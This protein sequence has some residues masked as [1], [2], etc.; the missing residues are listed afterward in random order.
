MLI[1]WMSTTF[2]GGLTAIGGTATL[3]FLAGQ[4]FR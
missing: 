3:L 4:L 1:E 2:T